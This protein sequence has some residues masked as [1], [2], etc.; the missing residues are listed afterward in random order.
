MELENHCKSKCKNV[1]EGA[2]CLDFYK[3]SYLHK[4]IQNISIIRELKLKLLNIIKPGCYQLEN[5]ISASLLPNQQY[6]KFINSC[7][8]KKLMNNIPFNSLHAGPAEAN[9][10]RLFRL[11]FCS[12]KKKN[13]SWQ[14]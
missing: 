1:K 6:A 2:M 12:S 3:N 9:F 14:Q 11:F 5:K 8:Y 13:I 4:K 10:F 7:F